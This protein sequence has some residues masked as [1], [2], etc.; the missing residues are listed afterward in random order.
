MI[1]KAGGKYVACSINTTPH[2]DQSI[3]DNGYDGQF[4]LHMVGST[5][6][7]TETTNESHQAAINKAYNWAH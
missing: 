4:C 1:L 7:G 5:T 2:G 3:T 6:H